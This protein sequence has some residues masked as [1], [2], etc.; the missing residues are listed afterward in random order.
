MESLGTVRHH[1]AVDHGSWCQR[2]DSTVENP[3]STKEHVVPSA[4][5]MSTV[6]QLEVLQHQSFHVPSYH[7]PSAF[8]DSN[9]TQS[10]RLVRSHRRPDSVASLLKDAPLPT[11]NQSDAQTE[12]G[13]AMMNSGT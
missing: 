2:A 5:S 10:R 13:H 4:T 11:F 9:F 1:T 12:D 7:V 6:Y 8:M 3:G